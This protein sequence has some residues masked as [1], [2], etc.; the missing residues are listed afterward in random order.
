V[1]A[2]S[3]TFSAISATLRTSRDKAPD[4]VA[5]IKALDPDFDLRENRPL[6]DA[7]EKRIRSLKL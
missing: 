6:L 7:I 3:P 2:P 1:H 4:Y 5:A